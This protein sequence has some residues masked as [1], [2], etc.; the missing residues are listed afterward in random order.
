MIAKLQKKFISLSFYL[1]KQLRAHRGLPVYATRILMYHNIVNERTADKFDVRIDAFKMQMDFLYKN[2]FNVIT[3]DEMMKNIKAGYEGHKDVVLTFDD[4]GMDIY[5]YAFPILKEYNFKATIFLVSKWISE[6]DAVTDKK[7]YLGLKEIREM[8]SYGISFGS[9]S[10][11]HKK[12]TDLSIE[13]CRDEIF[14]SKVKLGKTINSEIKYFCYPGGFFNEDIKGLVKKAGYSAACSTIMYG[15]NTEKDIYQLKRI[16]VLNH[17][18]LFD[19]KMQLI[20]AY[21]WL[22]GFR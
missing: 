10:C 6:A 12:L 11:H 21:D 3:F 7:K 22:E 4:G 16:W 2:D 1:Y 17:D 13:R 15:T 20:G 5:L 19:F 9:H 14:E 8:Q 18:S